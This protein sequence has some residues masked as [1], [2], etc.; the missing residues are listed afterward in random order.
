MSAAVTV[1]STSAFTVAGPPPSLIATKLSGATS[2][3]YFAFSPGNAL[4]AVQELRRR[5]EFHLGGM[6]SEVRDAS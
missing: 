1:P 5:T 3:P 6:R 4:G 2:R